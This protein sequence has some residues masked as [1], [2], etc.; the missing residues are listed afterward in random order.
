MND[1]YADMFEAIKG[2]YVNNECIE[3]KNYV[4]SGY[5]VAC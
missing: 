4:L 5:G 1:E 2:Y 3:E